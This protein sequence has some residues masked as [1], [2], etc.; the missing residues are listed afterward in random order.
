MRLLVLVAAF[1]LSPILASAENCIDSFKNLSLSSFKISEINRDLSIDDA[2]I[3]S[4]GKPGSELTTSD[5]DHFLEKF[6]Q[7][8]VYGRRDVPISIESLMKLTTWVEESLK[9][10][11][12]TTALVDLRLAQSE[13]DLLAQDFLK[14]IHN[15]EPTKIPV[16]GDANS[17]AAFMN[18]AGDLG[19][20]LYFQSH[21]HEHNSAKHSSIR[22][23]ALL[24]G[25][26]TSPSIKQSFVD[27]FAEPDK[28]EQSYLRMIKTYMDLKRFFAHNLNFEP[29]YGQIQKR[30]DPD[31]ITVF[32]DY[33]IFDPADQ[34]WK[35][36]IKISYQEDLDVSYR[37]KAPDGS[38]RSLRIVKEKID[39]VQKKEFGDHPSPDYEK[40][41]SDGY[42]TGVV[43]PDS[44]HEV[45]EAYLRYLRGE[46]Y[47][48]S[49][50]PV[51][52]FKDFLE[53]GITNGEL[54]F[55]FREA[56]GSADLYLK[57]SGTLVTAVKEGSPTRKV[58]VLVPTDRDYSTEK[59]KLNRLS[60]LLEERAHS[61]PNNGR[62]LYFDSKC[63]SESH[64]SNA[65]H[66]FCATAAS[67]ID[68]IAV[69][70][71]STEFQNWPS[72]PARALFHGILEQ[73]PYDDIQADIEVARKLSAEEDGVEYSLH[74]GSDRILTPN[75][76]SYQLR[77]KGGSASIHNNTHVQVLSSEQ[78]D[79]LRE[80]K[81][82]GYTLQD[83]NL[84]EEMLPST[85]DGGI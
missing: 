60:E 43:F 32:S 40:W 49:E 24:I 75:L 79:V 73:K 9:N 82:N 46:G 65:K 63:S 74:S 8:I 53:N 11:E 59:I 51:K 58:Y 33:F 83:M 54:D 62:L 21:K 42:L 71:P 36:E 22:V 3:A 66:S 77:I 52:K 69:S 35:R 31:G 5:I 50:E 38:E 78:G 15:A 84:E 76:E 39:E 23:I 61:N 10:N 30:A 28:S 64:L 16:Q 4:L 14:V 29:S 1:F 85:T 55:L 17:R 13:R 26:N 47:S 70:G 72:S 57:S 27:A 80:M 41:G 37:L 48:L 19:N 12:L 56:H 6:L 25:P 44:S 18:L 81:H 45:S 67:N 34:H 7:I 2:F 68:M 20:H